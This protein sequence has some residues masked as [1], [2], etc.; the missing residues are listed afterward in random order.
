MDAIDAAQ[1]AER[2]VAV[3]RARERLEELLLEGV[4][5]GPGEVATPEYWARKK[6][7]LEARAIELRKRKGLP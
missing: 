3:R 1:G 5:S 2:E 7:E 6:A 4:N